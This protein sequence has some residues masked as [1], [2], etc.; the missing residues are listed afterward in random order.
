MLLANVL[1]QSLISIAFALIPA[2]LARMG[3]D[4]DTV[5]RAPAF[6]YILA[7]AGYM[8]LWM[9]RGIDAYRALQRPLP[10]TLKLNTILMVVQLIILALCASGTIAS[11]SYLAALLLSLYFSGSSFVRVFVSIG[12]NV[13]TN[14]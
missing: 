1:G 6:A 11:S 10:R 7:Q 5:F 13:K 9:P 8:A 2:A 3:F 12:K 14:W 4:S